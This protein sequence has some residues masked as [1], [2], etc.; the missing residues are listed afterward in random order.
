MIYFI[1]FL[2]FFYSITQL[3]IAFSE[4]CDPFGVHLSLGDYFQHYQHTNDLTLLNA[5][6]SNVLMKITFMTI[7]KCESMY[8]I[9]NTNK[10]VNVSTPSPYDASNVD[11]SSNFIIYFQSIS[12]TTNLGLPY[13]TEI[14]YSLV[15]NRT[16]NAS[17]KMFRFNIPDRDADRHDLIITGAMDLSTISN[18]TFMAL[19]LLANQPKLATISAVLYTGN[20]AYNLESNDFEKGVQ[21]LKTLQGFAAFWPFMPTAGKY[22]NYDD[23]NFFN[24]LYSAINDPLFNNFFFSFNLGKAHIIQINMAFY[25]NPDSDITLRNNIWEWLTK[26][27]I[28]ANRSDNRQERP[29][30]IVY[31]FYSFYCSSTDDSCCGNHDFTYS[32]GDPTNPFDTLE[33][34]FKS[35]AVDLYISSSNSSSLYERLPPIYQS[36]EMPHSSK[37]TPDLNQLYMI[38]PRS[39]IYIVEG[40]GGNINTSD[41][42]YIE[43][44]GFTIS[45]LK[46]PGYAVLSIYNSTVLTYHHLA[47][48]STDTDYDYFI[49]INTLEKWPSIWETKDKQIFAASFILFLIFGVIILVVFM[50]YIEAKN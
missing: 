21:F 35:Y 25:F 40:I 29:W 36:A 17:K 5:Q 43:K 28:N 9:I 48:S 45:Q 18:S 31:G 32:D 14:L 19:D 26:D 13:N 12:V 23:F 16:A 41:N 39:T 3:K 6:S 15:S 22:D 4:D 8:A 20:M 11:S 50:L 30:I 47:S 42:R 2:I 27:L 34:L 33:F 10:E 44:T 1:K 49:L 7:D 46:N 37:I 38:N 24:Y